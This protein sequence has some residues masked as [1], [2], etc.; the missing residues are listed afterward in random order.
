MVGT[1]VSMPW[2]SKGGISIWEGQFEEPSYVETRTA[3]H[4]VSERK[5]AVKMRSTGL[6]YAQIGRAM[7]LPEAQSQT[8]STG[9]ASR[10]MNSGRINACPRR[11]SPNFRTS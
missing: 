9:L 4:L 10:P 11:S 3:E 1:D 8:C 5:E 6:T 7:L 2:M